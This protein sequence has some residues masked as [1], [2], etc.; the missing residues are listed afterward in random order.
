MSKPTA[1]DMEGLKR[2]AR[3]LAGKPR[4]ILHF[5]WQRAPST[6]DVYSDSDRA[7]CVRTRRSTSGGALMRGSHVLKT[8]STTQPTIALSSA[9]AELIAAVRGAAEGLTA[10]TLCTDF[11]RECKLRVHLDS[12]AAVGVARRRGVG[13]IRHLDTR[14]LWIQERVHAGD[15]WVVKVAG[16]ENPAD[17]MTKHLSEEV[18][19]A[20]MVRLGCWPREG[21]AAIAPRA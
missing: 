6:L 4:V 21:R 16:T 8:W 20:C 19:S 9:E 3:Y 14:L 2:L 7:G 12:S 17:L 5:G 15:L 11:G 18:G 1:R 10:L 13:K